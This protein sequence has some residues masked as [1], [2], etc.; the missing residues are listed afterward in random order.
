ML[1]ADKCRVLLDD[2]TISDEE[3]EALRSALY[4]SV[5]LAFEVYWAKKSGSKNPVGLL[6]LINSED[7]V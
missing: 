6:P 5:Q 4:D 7:T 2:K 1:S 3:I